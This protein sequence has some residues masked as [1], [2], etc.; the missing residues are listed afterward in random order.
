MWGSRFISSYHLPEGHSIPD[1]AAPPSSSQFESQLR[2]SYL[3]PSLIS[4]I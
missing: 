3:S 1:E 2:Y 4:G